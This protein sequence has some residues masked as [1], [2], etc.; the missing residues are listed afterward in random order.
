MRTLWEAFDVPRPTHAHIHS[1]SSSHGQTHT[2]PCVLAR[3]L[4]DAQPSHIQT[5]S[6]KDSNIPRSTRAQTRFYTAANGQTHSYPY[7]L[8]PARLILVQ[9]PS[10][11]DAPILKVACVQMR[12]HSDSL[13]QTHSRPDPRIPRPTHIQ[14]HSRPDSL[15]RSRSDSLRLAQ[16]LTRRVTWTPLGATSAEGT[17]QPPSKYPQHSGRLL[18]LHWDP[19]RLSCRSGRGVGNPELLK[20]PGGVFACPRH[21]STG[22]KERNIKNPNRCESARA[23]FL[24]GSDASKRPTRRSQR[25]LQSPLTNNPGTVSGW[26]EG[27]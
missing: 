18:R 20:A 24:W 9:T 12:A 4:M 22:K 23:R 11:V 1:L 14:T 25:T 17:R 8:T 19:D 13:P 16:R 7:L 21:M 27:Q 2:Y 15:A 3:R 6:C 10:C 26:A 5:G